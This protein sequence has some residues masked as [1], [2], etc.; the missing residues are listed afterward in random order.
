LRAFFP[1]EGDVTF[2]TSTASSLPW[3][4][5]A[6]GGSG[7]GGIKQVASTTAIAAA[8]IAVTEAEA[9]AA[10][11][12]NAAAAAATAAA[13]AASG[14][15]AGSMS[16]GWSTNSRSPTAVSSTSAST[17]SS[18]ITFRPRS[19]R[20]RFYS[21]FD[22]DGSTAASDRLRS[23]AAALCLVDFDVA[24]RVLADFQL[25]AAAA[26]AQAAAA[27]ARRG[28]ARPRLTS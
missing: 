14:P 1:G 3:S 22:D 28:E 5:P 18:T 20:P 24:F 8:A 16:G 4:S 23:L 21:L 13:E 15:A 9:S 11:I 12:D 10:V 19:D 7:G 27:I 2:V 25:P 17:S 6:H 26:F